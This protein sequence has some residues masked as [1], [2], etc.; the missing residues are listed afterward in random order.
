[1]LKVELRPGVFGPALLL[2]R[3]GPSSRLRKLP[4]LGRRLKWLAVMV[5]ESLRRLPLAGPALAGP[6]LLGAIVLIVVSISLNMLSS[7]S[8]PDM[9][10]IR[11]CGGVAASS[12][13]LISRDSSDLPRGAAIVL[14]SAMLSVDVMFSR[15][16]MAESRR[17]RASLSALV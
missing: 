3:M 12:R 2:G 6:T 15:R 10:A 13:L 8:R 11:P 7:K 14:L 9:S 4:A 1:M 17:R 16:S 5:E